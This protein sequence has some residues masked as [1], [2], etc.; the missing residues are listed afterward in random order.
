M[1]IH[2]DFESSGQGHSTCSKDRL[3]NR[4]IVRGGIRRL[5]FAAD[6]SGQFDQLIVVAAS[7]FR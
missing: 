6:R 1:A 5:D 4:Q 7:H 3:V 2:D